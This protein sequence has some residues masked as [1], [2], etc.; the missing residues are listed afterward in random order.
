MFFIFIYFFIF[1]RKTRAS[2]AGLAFAAANP[3]GPARPNP[4]SGKTFSEKRQIFASAMEDIVSMNAENQMAI[5]RYCREHGSIEYLSQGKMHQ[6]RFEGF[7]Q[8]SIDGVFCTARS[9]RVFVPKGDVY[10]MEIVKGNLKKQARK[11]DLLQSI[12]EFIRCRWTCYPPAQLE[13]STDE[14][15]AGKKK[16]RNMYYEGIAIE[17]FDGINLREWL[18]AQSQGLSEEQRANVVHTDH[19]KRAYERAKRALLNMWKKGWVHRHMN[20]DHFRYQSDTDDIRITATNYEFVTKRSVIPT[21]DWMELICEDFKDFAITFL[22]AVLSPERGFV[23]ASSLSLQ[24]EASV[25]TPRILEELDPEIQLVQ[26]FLE[27]DASERSVE[28][29]PASLRALASSPSSSK[30]LLPNQMPES[31]VASSFVETSICFPVI[32]VLILMLLYGLQRTYKFEQAT[33]EK[34]LLEC[35]EI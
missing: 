16:R 18:V 3:Y 1:L 14:F 23:H 10:A 29:I 22:L 2:S 6:I 32:L 34:Q 5:E 28:D 7:Y 25:I 21:L 17:Y 15:F 33:L 11:M 35:E 31:H 9:T 12:P 26:T 30:S 13:I 4:Y 24:S 8:S 19:V 27:K 20:V